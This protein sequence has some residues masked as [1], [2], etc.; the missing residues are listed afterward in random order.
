MLGFLVADRT[1][2]SHVIRLASSGLT[3]FLRLEHVTC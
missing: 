3:E 2:R 1:L